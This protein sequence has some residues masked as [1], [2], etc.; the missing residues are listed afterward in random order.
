MDPRTRKLY[1]ELTHE[2]SLSNRNYMDYSRSTYLTPN[3]QQYYK[4]KSEDMMGVG[5]V[6][7]VEYGVE[8]EEIDSEE[9]YIE[10]LEEVLEDVKIEIQDNY[11]NTVKEI[12]TATNKLLKG[13][14]SFLLIKPKDFYKIS[15]KV[16]VKKEIKQ[17]VYKIKEIEENLFKDLIKSLKMR[18]YNSKSTESEYKTKDYK[19]FMME[20]NSVMNKIEEENKELKESLEAKEFKRVNSLYVE[21]KRPIHRS[22]IGKSTRKEVMPQSFI[23]LKVKYNKLIR[24]M[25][26][27]KSMIIKQCDAQMK[28]VDQQCKKL[29]QSKELFSENKQNLKKL[30]LK[31]NVEQVNELHKTIKEVKAPSLSEDNKMIDIQSRQLKEL[32]QENK[33]LANILKN[34][35]EAIR[36]LYNTVSSKQTDKESIIEIIEE[37]EQVLV[38][39]GDEGVAEDLLDK[40]LELEKKIDELN[41]QNE[42]YKE[43]IDSA[44][45]I[46]L[47][48]LSFVNSTSNENKTLQALCTQLKNEVKKIA[49]DN[50]FEW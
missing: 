28:K 46:T 43:D 16:A 39:R 24:K 17:Y 25:G 15:A 31:K 23:F 13:I 48:T 20:L 12:F 8:R 9:K 6:P 3:S 33:Q 14:C 29:K 37:L 34:M 40:T 5:E 47:E 2:F 44:I 30:I 19:I 27:M 7:V 1:E 32:E 18:K 35:D 22:R 4:K 41:E 42:K 50:N 45:K 38:K 21:R 49:E 26:V 10:E 11:D 36:K